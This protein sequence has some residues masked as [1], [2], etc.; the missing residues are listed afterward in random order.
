MLI[1]FLNYEQLFSCDII[2]NTLQNYSPVH[3]LSKGTSEFVIRD[4][5]VICYKCVNNLGSK[6]EILPVNE[7]QR[8]SPRHLGDVFIQD[9]YKLA[10]VLELLLSS[11]KWI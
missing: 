8:V 3:D 2:F 4:A 10:C 6:N 7:L 1:F 11:A 5:K 9:V